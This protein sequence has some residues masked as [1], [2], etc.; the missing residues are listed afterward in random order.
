MVETQDLASV[1]VI[2]LKGKYIFPS[3]AE[4]SGKIPERKSSHSFLVDL[5]WYSISIQYGL[6]E[7]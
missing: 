7:C 1:P 6:G 2:L 5:S 4:K 3:L